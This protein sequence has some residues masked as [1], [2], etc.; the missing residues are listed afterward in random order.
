MANAVDWGE[1]PRF[2]WYRAA[3]NLKTHYWCG[4]FTACG[5]WWSGWKWREETDNKCTDCL[6]EKPWM[7]MRIEID[8]IARYCNPQGWEKLTSKLNLEGF[9]TQIRK[10]SIRIK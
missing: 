8:E 5:R 3:S 10:R 1:R 4:T 9:I 2:G 6:R 7:D